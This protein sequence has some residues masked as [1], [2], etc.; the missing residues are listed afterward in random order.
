MSNYVSP[1]GHHTICIY[2]LSMV[3]DDPA[4]YEVNGEPDNLY[5]PDFN[6]AF[7]ALQNRVDEYKERG[8]SPVKVLYVD[9][10]VDS[11]EPYA[12]AIDDLSDIPHATLGEP[13][14]GSDLRPARKMALKENE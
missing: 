4:A 14:D 7:E 10:T 2:H 5:F 11:N 12:T 1:E 13:Q 9:N 6:Q 8:W 3:P